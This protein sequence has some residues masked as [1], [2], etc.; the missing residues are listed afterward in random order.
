MKCFY[1]SQYRFYNQ[2]V[3]HEL[4]FFLLSDIHFS[5]RI[6]SQTLRA[7]TA[8]ANRVEPHYI[9]IAGDLIDSLDHIK[10]PSDLKRLT[11]WLKQLAKVAP[12]LIS[13]GNHEFY[14][15]N[16]K[17]STNS[18]MSKS[19]I[20]RLSR[21]KT[22]TSSASLKLPNIINSTTRIIAQPPFSTL[23]TKT[24][25]SWSPTSTH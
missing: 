13:L 9:L 14:H 15:K 12:V 19:S 1:H 3:K 5:Q 18:T 16:P 10:K 6:S 23:A 22:F 11:S 25:T 4:R 24:A 8:Q 21:I 17:P 20:I 7:I 2:Y